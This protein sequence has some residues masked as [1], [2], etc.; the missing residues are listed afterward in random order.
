EYVLPALGLSAEAVRKQVQ[1]LGRNPRTVASHW[2]HLTGAAGTEVAL[3]EVNEETGAREEYVLPAL[4]LSAEAVR[5]QVRLLGLNPRTVASHW[6]YLVGHWPRLE[7]RLRRTPDYLTHSLWDRHALRASY[8]AVL[9]Y[10]WG[11]AASGAP[12]P[13]FLDLEQVHTPL[14]ESA[15]NFSRRLEKAAGWG[16]EVSDWG[17][18]QEAWPLLALIHQRAQAGVSWDRNW[19]EVLAQ[20]GSVRTLLT[21]PVHAP[22]R[23]RMFTADGRLRDPA[24]MVKW[25]LPAAGMEEDEET[26]RLL[27]R[28][29]ELVRRGEWL[30][31]RDAKSAQRTFEEALVLVDE[32]VQRSPDSAHGW[33]RLGGVYLLLERFS[34]S[35]HAFE[36]A[37]GILPDDPHISIYLA[38]AY[39]RWDQLGLAVKVL[40]EAIQRH[41]QDRELYSRLG[42]LWATAVVHRRERKPQAETIRQMSTEEL[43]RRAIAAYEKAIELGEEDPNVWIILAGIYT[44][45]PEPAYAKAAEA[46]GEALEQTPQPWAGSMW[47]DFIGWRLAAQ[48]TDVPGGDE[49]RLGRVAGALSRL[50]RLH[51]VWEG[52]WLGWSP[53][54]EMKHVLEVPSEDIAAG[55]FSGRELSRILYGDDASLSE[56]KAQERLRLLGLA[57]PAMDQDW[58]S[59]GK[60]ERKESG[61]AFR[62]VMLDP[63]L[64]KLDPD[65]K[66]WLNSGKEIEGMIGRTYD[67]LGVPPKPPAAGLEEVPLAPDGSERLGEPEIPA[68]GLTVEGLSVRETGEYVGDDLAIYLNSG[69][70]EIVVPVADQPA[71]RRVWR[72][73]GWELQASLREAGVQV[74]DLDADAARSQAT[75]AQQARPGDVVLLPPGANVS[76]WVPTG[77]NLVMLVMPPAV[78]AGLTAPEFATLA[79][80]ARAHGGILHLREITRPALERP[81]LILRTAT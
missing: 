77:L 52:T 72:P 35:V 40:E 5:K 23:E 47:S 68:E 62:M 26:E 57:L 50:S 17:V 21:E 49:E 63:E 38:A 3:L 66:E 10:R 15:G 9:G 64:S 67:L 1:L 39:L 11:Q 25:P 16:I 18:F 22:L 60:L 44:G 32:A 12:L 42:H 81:L 69:E 70:E 24:Y 34:E 76:D 6:D 7:V 8:L 71:V 43:H 41:P 53:Q 27:K 4:G 80:V 73:A 31:E 51:N 14:M 29:D 65:R 37:A 56:P 55:D 59:S 45:P 58:R 20:E 19:P 54:V 33:T 2:E 30:A 75:L 46:L 78:A 28:V 48:S 36:K 61:I 13:R 74:K 79:A